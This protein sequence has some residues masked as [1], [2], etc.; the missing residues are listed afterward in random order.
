[1]SFYAKYEVTISYDSKVIANVEFFCHRR[2]DRTKLDALNSIPGAKKK[3]LQF[4]NFV[5]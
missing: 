3:K 4:Q 5:E 1:M 2:A